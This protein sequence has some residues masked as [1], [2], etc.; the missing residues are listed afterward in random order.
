[1]PDLEVFNMGCG[2]WLNELYFSILTANSFPE[3][4]LRFDYSK[5]R[6]QED[7]SDT[8]TEE[9]ASVT[10]EHKALDHEF[11]IRQHRCAHCV[12]IN[13]DRPVYLLRGAFGHGIPFARAPESDDLLPTGER[14]FK[15]AAPFRF[16]GGLSQTRRDI[17][18]Y[19]KFNES[20]G[21]PWLPDYYPKPKPPPEEPDDKDDSD[22]L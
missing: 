4:F 10:Q 17:L 9:S 22:S 11:Q 15:H 3:D 7:R 5:Y 1:M 13:Y 16:G 6:Y 12:H 14:M 8:S 18:Q 21:P 19:I 2:C 20:Y